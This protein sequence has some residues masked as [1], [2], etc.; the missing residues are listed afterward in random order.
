MSSE[1][2]GEAGCR[3]LNV[4]STEPTSA[5][6]DAAALGL[7]ALAEVLTRTEDGLV[8]VDGDRRYVYVNPAASRIL[9]HPIEQ[10]RGRDFLGSFQAP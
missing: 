2:L 8:V 3:G 4:P 7:S 9:G 10:L 1:V 6:A 5:L